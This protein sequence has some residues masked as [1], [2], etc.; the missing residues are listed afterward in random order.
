MPIIDL[1][2]QKKGGVGKTTCAS[3]YLQYLWEKGLPCVGCDVDP[4]NH[5]LYTALHG[6]IDVAAFS[7]L[8][9][10]R[11]VDRTRFDAVIESFASLPPDTHVVLDC[12]ASGFVPLISYLRSLNLLDFLRDELGYQVRIH[13]PVVGGVDLLATLDSLLELLQWFPTI[14]FVVWQNPIAGPVEL[15]A[16]RDPAT[17][18]IIAAVPLE[19]LKVIEDHIPQIFAIVKMTNRFMS[20]LFLRDL[21][22]HFLRNQTFKKTVH[23]SEVFLLSR[24]RVIMFWRGTKEAIEEAHLD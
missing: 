1:F 8:D 13:T 11:N 12:G 19:N 10:E 7:I 9:D 21:R 18:Q 2:L 5:T 15:P 4:S 3:F 24:Q 16:H 14:P 20:D 22:D 17:G 6:E 23:S